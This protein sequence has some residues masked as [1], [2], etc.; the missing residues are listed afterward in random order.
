MIRVGMDASHIPHAEWQSIAKVLQ[1]VDPNYVSGH[2]GKWGMGASPKVLGYDV[3]D[4]ATRNVDGGLSMTS[5]SG[6]PH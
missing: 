3:G 5:H 4:G 1:S 6:K 2:F